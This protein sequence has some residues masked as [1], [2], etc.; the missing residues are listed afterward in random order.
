M[1][2][3]LMLDGN[4]AAGK[5]QEL[6]AMEMTTAAGT[7]ENCGSFGELG[8][9]RLFRGAGL[10]FRCSTCGAILMTLVSGGHRSWISLR[11]I[12]ALEIHERSP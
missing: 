4:A 3:A 6:F 12:R 2:D 7:C 5:L 9:A 11:G 1:M 10:V 8:R